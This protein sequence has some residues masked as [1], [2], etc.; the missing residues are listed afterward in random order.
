MALSM[1]ACA[2]S[3]P[4]PM[5]GFH[6][7]FT[8]RMVRQGDMNTQIESGADRKPFD[9]ERGGLRFGQSRG[10]AGGK[11]FDFIAEFGSLEITGIDSTDKS[12]TPVSED[13]YYLGAQLK[14]DALKDQK[15]GPA[16]VAYFFGLGTG[17]Y[18]DFV[19]F[20]DGY[21]GATLG[22][23]FRYLCP[24]VNFAGGLSLPYDRKYFRYLKSNFLAVHYDVGKFHYATSLWL[25]SEMGIET[26]FGNP[27]RGLRLYY[28]MGA[29][30]FRLLEK[31]D[32]APHEVPIV[33]FGVDL[34]YKLGL[35]WTY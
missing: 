3:T 23:G 8:P 35:S 12:V 6:H 31:D 5:G 22:A 21:G 7:D 20:V 32:V 24:F 34:T 28:S 29:K 30:A 10:L 9:Q 18:G 15:P 11:Q 16:L 25:G 4:S 13:G 2:I 26:P 14:F 33:M 19:S 27:R 17:G 1:T